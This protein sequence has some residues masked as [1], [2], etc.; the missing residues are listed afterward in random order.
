M[1]LGM[2]VKADES[3]PTKRLG[4][5][6]RRR[7]L[8]TI[9]PDEARSQHTPGPWHTEVIGNTI[10]VSDCACND[11]CRLGDVRTFGNQSNARLIASAPDLLAAVREARKFCPVELQDRI[12][13][14]LDRTA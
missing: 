10:R 5:R 7:L 12:D 4:W 9:S 13:A 8:P 14:I 1:N 6:Q 2:R 3:K 11:V